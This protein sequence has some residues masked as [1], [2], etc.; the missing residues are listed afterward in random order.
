MKNLGITQISR[1]NP[2]LN[3]YK[4]TIRNW[5]SEGSF[6]EVLESDSINTMYGV[7]YDDHFLGASIM[8]IDPE[9]M[10]ANVHCVNGSNM[11]RDLIDEFF[12]MELPRIANDYGATDVVFNG[13]KRVENQKTYVK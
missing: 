2:L 10:I 3:K 7:F 11:H 8:Q 1:N 12:S 9:T 13:V 6:V 5:D 4:N